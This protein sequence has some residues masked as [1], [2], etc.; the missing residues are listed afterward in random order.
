MD[1]TA[2]NNSPLGQAFLAEARRRL[3]ACHQR[4]K[5]CIGQLNDGQVWWRADSGQNSIANI[6]LHLCGNVRQWIIA[7]IGGVPDQRDRP[8]EFAERAPIPKERLERRLDEVVAEA[9]AVLARVSDA[10]LL[11]SRR[12]QGFDETGLSAISNSVAH[13]AGHTQEIVFITRIQLR[14]RYR[15]AWH[16]ATPEQGAVP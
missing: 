10:Q 16:P 12:I 7:G 11:G 3:A 4:I 14:D 9:D 6:L 8:R 15:F 5:H 1:E 13:F 2:P